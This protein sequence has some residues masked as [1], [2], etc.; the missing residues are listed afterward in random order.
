MIMFSLLVKIILYIYGATTRP[1]IDLCLCVI[2]TYLTFPSF[3]KP[4]NWVCACG[5]TSLQP[6]THNQNDWNAK[7]QIEYFGSALRIKQ[8]DLIYQWIIN[9]INFNTNAK[10]FF[11]RE[12]GLRP[13]INAFCASVLTVMGFWWSRIRHLFCPNMTGNS[14]SFSLLDMFITFLAMNDRYVS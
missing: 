9:I 2:I 8:H 4:T 10:Y 7:N 6:K 12:K 13:P 11:P 5:H 3:L 14:P 1:R